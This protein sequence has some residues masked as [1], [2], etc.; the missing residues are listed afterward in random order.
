MGK[1]ARMKQTHGGTIP[2]V[3]VAA[4][5]NIPDH[6]SR[7]YVSGTDTVTSLCAEMPTIEGRQL[8][9][10]GSSG[11]AT[12]TNTDDTTTK[13]QM[14]LGGSNRAVGTDDVLILT[15]RG[16]GTWLMTTALVNN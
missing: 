16:N 12:F 14:D 5:M 8:V 4:A 9:I 6:L 2:T 10:I 3:T 15:Q 7:V 1:L 11:T 13:G